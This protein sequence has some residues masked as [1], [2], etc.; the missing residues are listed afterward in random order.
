MSNWT[1]RLDAHHARVQGARHISEQ[2]HA[3]PGQ[4]RIRHLDLERAVGHQ[5]VA[6][7]QDRPQRIAGLAGLERDRR[8]QVV[9]E[10]DGKPSAASSHRGNGASTPRT[11][12]LRPMTQIT[13]SHSVVYVP[14]HEKLTSVT[15]SRTSS[16]HA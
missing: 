6:V 13:W 11:I 2:N 15:S 10:H 4:Q 12:M 5:D 16:S 1:R 3:D 9:S 14:A 7:V 8:Q